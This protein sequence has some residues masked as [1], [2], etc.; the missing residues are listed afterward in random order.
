MALS[1]R[2]LTHLIVLPSGQATAN[3]VRISV[4]YVNTVRIKCTHM[5][6][7][8][9]AA[10]LMQ[11][12]T[13]FLSNERTRHKMRTMADKQAQQQRVCLRVQQQRQPPSSATLGQ[14]C[15]AMNVMQMSLN[16][17]CTHTGEADEGSKQCPSSG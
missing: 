9:L 15:A 12:V 14:V 2:L 1:W 3:I 17:E 6:M 4:C 10:C 13:S 7:T 5:L 11:C 8:S 16:D